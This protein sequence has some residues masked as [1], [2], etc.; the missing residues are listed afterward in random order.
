MNQSDAP[1]YADLSEPDRQTVHRALDVLKASIVGR[2]FDRPGAVKDY[3]TLKYADLQ[4][5]VF[6]VLWLDAQNRLRSEEVLFRGTLTQTSVY[7]REVVKQGLLCNAGGVILFHNHPSG[8]SEPSR[9][10]EMLTQT[11]KQA[12]ALVDIRLVDHLVVSA[13]GATSLAER[14]TL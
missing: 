13:G 7:P 6:G 3:L 10:D 4:H 11:L 9:A 14:G 2:V 12:L 8:C 1:T 5:E